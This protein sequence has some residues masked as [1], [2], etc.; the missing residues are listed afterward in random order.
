MALFVKLFKNPGPK[1]MEEIAYD[2]Q[3]EHLNNMYGGGGG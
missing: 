3:T 1:L 2:D